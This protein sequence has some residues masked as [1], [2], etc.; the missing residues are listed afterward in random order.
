MVCGVDS[1]WIFLHKSDSSI[2]EAGLVQRWK[3]Y[4]ESMELVGIDET[5]KLS[6]FGWVTCVCVCESE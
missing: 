4:E 6:V 2:S 5:Y 3:L 1:A